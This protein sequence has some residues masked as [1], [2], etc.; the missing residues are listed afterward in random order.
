MR[1]KDK[2]LPSTMNIS[3]LKTSLIFRTENYR[4]LKT[5]SILKVYKIVQKIS[6][7]N[8]SSQKKIIPQKEAFNTTP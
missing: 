4:T 2:K 8:F 1:P 5:N 3:L 6:L 7:E